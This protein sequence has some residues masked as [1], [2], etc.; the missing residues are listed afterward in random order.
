MSEAVRRVP[1]LTRAQV[2][3]VVLGC[4][5]PEAEQGWNVARQAVFLAKW[6]DTVTA[7]TINRFCSSGLQSI[8]HAAQ[9]ISAAS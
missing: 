3:D 8:V 9:E 7:E 2:Q 1:G 4:A 5:M 6:P